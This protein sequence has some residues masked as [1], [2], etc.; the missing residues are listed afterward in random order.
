LFVQVDRAKARQAVLNLLSNAYKY[1][2]AGGEVEVVI[3]AASCELR[4]PTVAIRISD[5]GIGMTPGQLERIFER[6]YR[7]DASS[8]VPGT[9]LGM[10]IV[11]EIV[12]MHSG[13]IKVDSTAGQG[14]RVC[15][16]L[17]ADIRP[18]EMPGKPA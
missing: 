18:D 8:K 9:G 6:F 10:S 7:A 16:C 1:S 17:P 14:T 3:E 4:S 11:K 15:L 2:P 5:H 12:D 13:H